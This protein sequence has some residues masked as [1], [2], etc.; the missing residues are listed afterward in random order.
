MKHAHANP[1]AVEDDLAH[2]G[3]VLVLN[4][5]V[6]DS[7]AGFLGRFLCLLDLMLGQ[8]FDRYRLAVR[9]R[10]RLAGDLLGWRRVFGGT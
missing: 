1:S 4:H 10:H 9:P 2:F 6:V 3:S 8:V 7:V 5:P